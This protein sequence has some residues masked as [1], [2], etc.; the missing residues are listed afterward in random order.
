MHDAAHAALREA[1][2][3]VREPYLPH[4]L[5]LSPSQRLTEEGV[6]LGLVSLE[7]IIKSSETSKDE[8]HF[9]V[10]VGQWLV[11]RCKV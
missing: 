5:V 1:Q 4:A 8:E 6:S 11:S 2:H 3:A 10:S 9:E 7:A